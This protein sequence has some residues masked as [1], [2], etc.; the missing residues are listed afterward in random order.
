[1]RCQ[2]IHSMESID[3][4]QWNRVLGSDYPFLRHQ[5]L[6]A[7]EHSQCVG[8]TR[9]WHPHHLLVFDDDQL[10]ALM[11]L[12]LKQHSYG[13]YVFD[14]S[15]AE[16][17]QKHG[18]QYYPKLIAAIPFTPAS[19][20]R[21]C[22]TLNHPEE[23]HRLIHKVTAHLDSTCAERHYSGWHVLFPNTDNSALWQQTR[24]A[25]RIA[26]HFQWF[27]REYG[28]FD[29]FLATF[30]SRK[31]KNVRKERRRVVEQGLQVERLTGDAIT[32]EHWQQFYRCYQMTYAKRS[33]HGG[34]L[35]PEFFACL[36]RDCR[37]QILLVIA[38]DGDTL[39]A[40]ALYFFDDTTLYG[41]YWGALKN[42]DGLHFEA[43]YYQG[44]E[45]CIEQGLQRF[46]PG[47]QGEHKIMRGFEPV[48][49]ESYHQLKDPEFF[50]AIQ[51]FVEEEATMVKKYQ[52]EARQALPF[53]STSTD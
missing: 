17:Y 52:A 6:S 10:I 50:G 2:F 41:R 39:V 37:Q 7:L 22:Y 34:Y 44:I 1:M 11:P 15:W 21:L 8:D 33:G 32:A 27:N 13:E 19:G 18:L 38:K 49:T 53:K 31:R 28:S 47:V 12:Y 29:D 40:S 30:S 35:T 14:W 26:C 51:H 16:A 42:Y 43:C 46:D 36:Q 20:P 4:E 9:G 45:F 24:A 48:I 3:A 25:R 5:F 23:I